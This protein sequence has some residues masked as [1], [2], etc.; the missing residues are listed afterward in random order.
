VALAAHIVAVDTSGLAVF[1]PVADGAFHED[2]FLQIFQE[3]IADQA[4]FFHGDPYPSF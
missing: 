4:F 3:G 1:L 2:I